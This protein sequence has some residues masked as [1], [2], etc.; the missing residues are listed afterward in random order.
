MSDGRDVLFVRLGGIDD[1]D[2]NGMSGGW[3][4]VFRLTQQSNIV[5]SIVFQLQVARA[6]EGN[7]VSEVL[8]SLNGQIVSNDRVEYLAQLKGSGSGNGFE[9]TPF[10][11][12]NL[13]A[14]NVEAGNHTLVVGGHLTEKT[15]DNEVTYIR[16][17]EVQVQVVS[18]PT[19]GALVADILTN[20]KPNLRIRSG[21]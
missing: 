15:E 12:V 14:T 4:N 1:T 16:F 6:F 13:T 21:R 9:A 5:I 11:R 8:C 20:T 17:D 19:V 18:E 7:E 10:Q 3:S 2:V